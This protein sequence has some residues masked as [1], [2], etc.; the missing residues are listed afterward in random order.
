MP[1]TEKIS[2][3]NIESD[4]FD[5][6]R[7]SSA[8][9]T[10]L[11]SNYKSINNKL[12]STKQAQISVSKE[13]FRLGKYFK[14]NQSNTNNKHSEDNEN[15][16]RVRLRKSTGL[17]LFNS[18]NRNLKSDL[19]TL[20]EE[21]RF[22]TSDTRSDFYNQDENE[23]SAQVQA[24]L[25]RLSLI[26]DLIDNENLDNLSFSSDDTIDLISEARNY[27]LEDDDLTENRKVF[28]TETKYHTSSRN[29]SF[30]MSRLNQDD[31]EYDYE[32]CLFFIKI[33][34]II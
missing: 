16:Q 33:P 9:S 15:M 22:S 4:S 34:K 30:N 7:T 31:Y 26:Q 28:L 19:Y 29:S 12:D 14:A 20:N 2:I 1:K 18:E 23:N 21:D 27:C 25:D 13:P 5:V 10:T 11:S 32:G 17:R 6:S 8:S 24:N 3:K